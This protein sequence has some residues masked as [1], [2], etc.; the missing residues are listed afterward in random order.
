MPHPRPRRLVASILS[1]IAAAALLSP[2]PAH[3]DTTTAAAAA[4]TSPTSVTVTWAPSQSP[5]TSWVVIAKR[6]TDRS[7]VGIRTVCATCTST[8]FDYLT[9]GAGYQFAVAGLGTA[10]GTVWGSAL[11]TTPPDPLCV[12]VASCVAVDATSSAGPSTGV[13][14][15]LLRGLTSRTDPARVA[16]L[17]LKYHRTGAWETASFEAARR[18]GGKIDVVL[19]DAWPRFTQERAGRVMNPWED[20]DLY[21]QFVT[22]VVY[23]HYS[24]NLVPDYWEIQNEPDE[25]AS[26]KTAAAG[27]GPTRARVLQ[28]F[29]VAHDTIRA[30]IPEAKIVGPSTGRFDPIAGAVLDVPS[31]LDFADARALRFDVIA[32]HEMGGDCGGACDAGPRGIAQ[33]LATLQ[34]L[35]AAR[36]S[37]GQPEVH[38]NEFG[39]PT[40]VTN[41]GYAVG[42]FAAL[43]WSGVTAAGSSCW[44]V[45]YSGRTY[46]GCYY[47]PGTMDNLLMPNGTTPTAAWWVWKAYAGMTG[48]QLGATASVA[49]ASVHATRSST[50]VVNM[51][52]G[53]H[54]ASTTVASVRV[55]LRVPLE[56][57]KVQVTVTTIAA[58]VG[59]STPTTTT[60]TV[61]ASSGVVDLGTL[62][63]AGGAALSLQISGADPTSVAALQGAGTATATSTKTSSG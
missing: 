46:D 42:Y 5:A 24:H 18:A 25:A 20:W 50:G 2:L 1:V 58:T 32:W 10:D 44:P 53:R 51:L 21:R 34:E 12:G 28:Q 33:H 9:P 30:A 16:A 41:P 54:S 19:S 36:P 22:G 45:T 26:Y 14:L 23:W 8:R 7:I 27:M 60:R 61:S 47:D 31:F 37:L 39:G 63:V 57:R 15:G 38:I 29:Q 43:A 59:A 49:D 3:A 62:S 52:V 17:T 13:G 4:A 40:T 35:L 6:A 11:A 56:V 48:Q 55:R